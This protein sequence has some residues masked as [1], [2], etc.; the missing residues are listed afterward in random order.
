M[1]TDQTVAVLGAGRMGAAMVRTLRQAGFDVVVYNR[2][3]EPARILADDVGATIA[4]TPRE[5]AEAADVI[6]SSLA[7]DAAVSAVYS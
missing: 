6:I 3:A 7:D 4:S 5:A 1:T 2:S